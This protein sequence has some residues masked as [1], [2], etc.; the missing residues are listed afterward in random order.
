MDKQGYKNQMTDL[1]SENSELSGEVHRL[2]DENTKLRIALC[3]LRDKYL[4]IGG[5][6]NQLELFDKDNPNQLKIYDDQSN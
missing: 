6:V 1:I 2:Q 5:D 3:N 4:D